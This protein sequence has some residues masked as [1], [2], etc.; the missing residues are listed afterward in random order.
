MA[1]EKQDSDSKAD[2]KSNRENRRQEIALAVDRI[3]PQDIEA[4][5]SILGYMMSDKPALA[6]G[7]EL[8]NEESFYR[9]AHR[10]I[11]L[12]MF[13]LFESGKDVNMISVS[14]KLTQM[15]YLE[16]IGGNY[17]LTEL[18]NSCISPEV[19]RSHID[20]VLDKAYKRKIITVCQEGVAIAFEST[21][22]FQSIAEGVENG[23]F[24]VLTTSQDRGFKQV[25][26]ILY[27]NFDNI[28]ELHSKKNSGITGITSGFPSLDR[29][30]TG[31][32]PSDLIIL[33]ARPSIGK[34]SLALDFAINSGVPTGIFSIEMSAEQLVNRLICNMAKVDAHKMRSG[35]LTDKD[36][37][38][39]AAKVALI[40]EL[41]IFIDDSAS[42][43]S[44]EIRT[45]VR[46]LQME[47][48]IGLI[49]IDYLQLVKGKEKGWGYN[50]QAEIT[51]ISWSLKALAK[52]LKIPVIALSQLSREVEKR[53]NNRPILSDLRES[54]AIE[55]D[56]DLVMFIYRPE[57]SYEEEGLSEIIIAKQR[58]GPTGK[59]ELFFHK[60][61]TSFSELETTEKMEFIEDNVPF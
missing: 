32:H 34:T 5:S 1:E 19:I 13:E 21:E 2:K 59:I 6:K 28:S 3:P 37:A 24:G 31:F 15:E 40:A 9:K 17:Y 44:T 56:S 30:T 4:E 10:K 7:V 27:N 35:K 46:R 52:E 55:Q 8:L 51:E 14:D 23:I 54:G 41:P 29:L 42:L 47:K 49:I 25:G 60:T 53:K 43:N 48:D 36:F 39:I 45:K 61:Y 50:R 16:E 58:N 22:G 33:A 57:M 18:L 26:G 38:R 12:A 11:F 20:I